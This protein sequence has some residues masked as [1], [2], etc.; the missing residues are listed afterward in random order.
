MKNILTSAATTLTILGFVY[1]PWV[2]FW[3]VWIALS[4]LAFRYLNKED[5]AWKEKDYAG[6]AWVFISVSP[7]FWVGCLV[8]Y[9]N[10]NYNLKF[11]W[12]VEVSKISV[13]KADDELGKN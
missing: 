11:R 13:D 7:I 8:D 9:I 2:A 4:V 5:P 1:F 6:A 10:E 12:P 3:A